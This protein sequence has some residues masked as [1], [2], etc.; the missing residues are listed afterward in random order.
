MLSA[1][2][3]TLYYTHTHTYI[4]TQTLHTHTHYTYTHAHMHTHTGTCPEGRTSLDQPVTNLTFKHHPR[5][6]QAN[7]TH[8]LS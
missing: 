8:T 2:L 3:I 5:K 4:H 1:N 7:T 6:R